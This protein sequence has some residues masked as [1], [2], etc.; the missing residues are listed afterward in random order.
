M[1]GQGSAR[2]SRQGPRIVDNRIGAV[3]GERSGAVLVE[4]DRVAGAVERQVAVDDQAREL[5]PAAVAD[6]VEHAAGADV[7]RRPNWKA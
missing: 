3:D 7:S 6:E 5:L 1:P 4:V 2:R